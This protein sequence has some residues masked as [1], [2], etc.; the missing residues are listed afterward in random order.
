MLQPKYFFLTL[1]IGL[2]F[3]CKN[4]ESQQISKVE[5]I[6][7]TEVTNEI[8]QEAFIPSPEFKSYWYSGKAEITSYKLEQAR[9]GELRDGTAV[10]IY[11]TED[12]LP[13]KQVKADNYNKSN[14]PVLKLNATKNFNTG[15]Y[16][17][18]IMQSTFYPVANTQHALKVTCSVQEWCGQVY[19]QLNNRAQ[20]EIESHSYFE[21]E[22]D[23][24][25]NL[26]KTILEN[27]LWTQLRI[28]PTSL[29]TGTF[30]MIPSFEFIRLKHID[31]KAYEAKAE[32]NKG[33]YKITYPELNRTLTINFNSNFPYNITDWE[34]TYK[35][36]FG[37]TAEIL[38][39]KAIKLNSINSAYWSKNSNSDEVLRETLQLN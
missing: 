36:G 31:L 16:P 37:K 38:T 35:D 12:F 11:V 34:E 13:E 24:D 17:Y 1:F 28:D 20:F 15:I 8:H 7:K 4:Q 33:S 22:G 2:I 30:E 23:Q 21:S 5:T 25:F 19:S 6:S 9:Y 3:S 10:L 29:P 14:T 27:E 18:A 26:D 39:T 32:L